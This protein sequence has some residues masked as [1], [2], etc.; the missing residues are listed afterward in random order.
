MKRLFMILAVASMAILSTACHVDDGL[1]PYSYDLTVESQHWNWDE[2]GG[3][4][5]YHFTGVEE[6]TPYVME[7]S[8]YQMYVVRRD[9]SVWVQESLP[10][11]VYHEENDGYR[12]E[13]TIA[14]DY[15]PREIMFYVRNSDFLP[16][17]RPGTMDFRLVVFR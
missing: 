11:T 4:Y 3:Y 16:D 5:F 17:L 12:W 15:S 2:A 9:G 10:T 8:L 14:C 13:Y 1:Q 7:N 6:L